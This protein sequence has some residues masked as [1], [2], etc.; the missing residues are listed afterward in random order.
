MTKKQAIQWLYKNSGWKKGEWIERLGVSYAQLRKWL[1]E[2]EVN[3]GSLTVLKAAGLFHFGV[4]W[5]DPAQKDLNLYPIREELAFSETMPFTEEMIPKKLRNY[6][7]PVRTEMIDGHQGSGSPM[8][9]TLQLKDSEDWPEEVEVDLPYRDT[10]DENAITARVTDT[11]MIPILKP[12]MIVY[13]EPCE[14]FT[15][16]DLILVKIPGNGALFGEFYQTGGVT[17]L[18]RLNAPT[19]QINYD[20]GCLFKIRWINIG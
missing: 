10:I 5:L 11:A 15:N 1:S 16:G 12:G 17:L 4:E 19:M 14:E 13:A 7:E 6:E 2:D 3:I 20:Q 18:I 9:H 8:V